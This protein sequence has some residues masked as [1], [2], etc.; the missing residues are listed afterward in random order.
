[1]IRL[2]MARATAC[3]TAKTGKCRCRCG[4]IL[5]GKKRGDDPAFFEGLPKDDPHFAKPKRVRKPRILKRDRVP[6]L[7][8][9]I[10]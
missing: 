7:F 2:S 9:G 8:E 1:V 10:V 4:G 6:P 3:E 5:H